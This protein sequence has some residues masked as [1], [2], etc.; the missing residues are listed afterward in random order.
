LEELTGQSGKKLDRLR[1]VVWYWVVAQDYMWWGDERLQEN[2]LPK[3]RVP[4]L[5]L[6][7][8]QKKRGEGL[9]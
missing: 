1:H 9:G 7:D 4:S 5:S 3:K 2:F 6:Q 8:D